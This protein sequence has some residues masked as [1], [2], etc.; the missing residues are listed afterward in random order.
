MHIGHIGGS[1][2]KNGDGTFDKKKVSEIHRDF[3]VRVRGERDKFQRNEVKLEDEI[4]DGGRSVIGEDFLREEIGRVVK[5]IDDMLDGGVEVIDVNYTVLVKDVGFGVW[6]SPVDRDTLSESGVDNF[7]GDVAVSEGVFRAEVEDELF[8]V[9]DFWV[10]TGR[11][12]DVSVFTDVRW[13]FYI[14]AISGEFIGK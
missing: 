13:A 6:V 2:E 10:V 8:N 14:D 1:L 9:I 5:D 11:D 3:L 4:I 7:F 12:D